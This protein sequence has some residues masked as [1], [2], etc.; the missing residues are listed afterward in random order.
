MTTPNIETKLTS[1]TNGAQGDVVQAQPSDTDEIPWYELINDAPEPPEDAMQQASLI[2]QVMSILWGRYERDGTA[3]VS[4]QTN[5]IYDS[6]VPGSVIV[7]DGYVVFDV[8]APLIEAE[9]RSYRIDEWG[10]PPDFVLEVASEST[11]R[12]DLTDKREIYAR[13]G[14]REYWRLDRHGY[15][16]EPLVGERLV[17]GEY[18]R[19]ELHAEPNG[20]VWSRSEVLSVDFYHRVEDGASVFLLRDSVT[21]ERLKTPGEEVL[22]RQAAEAHAQ[23][24]AY[25]RQEAEARAQEAVAR[26][27][28]AEA[29]A[30][31]EAYSRQEAEARAQEAEARTQEAEARTKEAEARNRELEAELDRLRQQQ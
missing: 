20:Y 14:V 16:G 31:E 17:D 6:A 12:R 15:Y 1:Q 22:A 26:A 28:E 11:A 23:E 30:Q 18:V 27:Q 25:S 29:H 2:L 13:M 19:V 5:V 9:R 4:E 24:E 7:P 3:L 21:G 10:K 8:P